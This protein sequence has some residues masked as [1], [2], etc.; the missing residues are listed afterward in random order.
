MELLIQFHFYLGINSMDTFIIRE[1]RYNKNEY[2]LFMLN[3]DTDTQH[4]TGFKTIDE[5][6]VYAKVHGY[7]L[8]K[9]DNQ[10]IGP[11][12]FIQ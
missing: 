7:Y 6:E 8:L 5:A 3:D 4:H 11:P 12:F 1:C 9:K 2:E 10:I